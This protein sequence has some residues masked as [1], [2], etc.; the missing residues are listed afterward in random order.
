LL[1][2]REIKREFSI[3]DYNLIN[4]W[5]GIIV[6]GGTMDATRVTTN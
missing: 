6:A 4:W 2:W 1:G 5:R 3:P